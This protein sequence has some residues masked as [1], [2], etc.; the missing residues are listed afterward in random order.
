MEQITGLAWL[1]GHVDDQPRIQRGPCD[2]NG[3]MHAAFGDPA[4]P[5]PSAT[6]PVPA[7]WSRRPMFEAALTVA[8]ELI[9]R[10]HRLRDRARSRGQSQPARRSAEPLRAAPARSSGWRCRSTTDAQWAALCGLLGRADWAADR[11]TGNA[12]GPSGTP[13]RNSTRR[14]P[15]GLQPG[16]STRR[17]RRCS[18]PGSRAGRRSTRGGSRRHPQY[19]R[20]RLLRAGRPPG[21]RYPSDPRR[22]RS[23]S[24][25][26][27]AGSVPRRRRSGSTT[28]SCSTSSGSLRPDASSSPR[29]T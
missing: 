26:S 29:R 2:P 22:C 11:A 10:V 28:T 5:S 7:A 21:G 24:P 23:A 8:A 20:P 19:R 17:S 6:A 4:S 16:R 9:D 12:R 13:R 14:S 25:R 15:T 3:G 1:T 27:S 18:P